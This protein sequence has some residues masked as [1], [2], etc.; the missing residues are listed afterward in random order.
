MKWELG[1]KHAAYFGTLN[2][3]LVSAQTEQ[4]CTIPEP[5]S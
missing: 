1:F 2:F 5:S 4:Q 3:R